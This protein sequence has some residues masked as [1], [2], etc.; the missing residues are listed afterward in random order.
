MKKLVCTVAS[1]AALVAP[2]AV[3]AQTVVGGALAYH[4]D[5][6]ALGIGAYAGIAAPQL[7]ENIAIN[8]SFIWYFPDLG[9]LWELNGDVVFRFPLTGQTS[10]IPFALGGINILR[11]SVA[12]ISTTDVGLNLGGG[13]IFPLPTVRPAVGAKFEIQDGT[14]FVLFGGVGFPLGS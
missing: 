11:Q 2:G 12:G 9:D 13:L 14:G 4:T 10:M 3:E 8:P 1:V 7:H 6:E 5:A